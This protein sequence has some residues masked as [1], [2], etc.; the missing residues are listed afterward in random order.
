MEVTLERVQMKP[1]HGEKLKLTLSRSKFVRMPLWCS[2][3]SFLKLS[4]NSF[5][6]TNLSKLLTI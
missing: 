3:L 2:L 4:I 1:F 5:V 6:V